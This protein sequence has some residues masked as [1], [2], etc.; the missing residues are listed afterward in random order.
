M[1]SFHLPSRSKRDSYPHLLKNMHVMASKTPFPFL[2]LLG[3]LFH[4][5]PKDFK[6]CQSFNSDA[7]GFLVPWDSAQPSLFNLHLHVEDPLIWRL[8][9]QTLLSFTS[10]TPTAYSIPSLEWLKSISNLTKLRIFFFFSFSHLDIYSCSLEF[11]R[12]CR[13]NGITSITNPLSLA[14]A[15]DARISFNLHYKA[16]R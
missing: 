5:L 13:R 6:C 9:A 12:T 4:S 15:L 16:L 10:I 7:L 3:V 14:P 2:L 8:P 11:Y 1:S